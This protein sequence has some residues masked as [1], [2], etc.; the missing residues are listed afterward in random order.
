[1][2]IIPFLLLFPFHKKILSNIKY[3]NLIGRCNVT[4]DVK[5][6]NLIIL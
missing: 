3:Q 5:Q 6:K 4:I 2:A 1:M